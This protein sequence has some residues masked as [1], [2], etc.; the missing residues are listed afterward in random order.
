[1]IFKFFLKILKNSRINMQLPK[2]LMQMLICAI[3]FLIAISSGLLSFYHGKD[4]DEM[5]KYLKYIIFGL[6]LVLVFVCVY[7]YFY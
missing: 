1:M 3:A 5:D 7:K 6:S 2:N 4:S